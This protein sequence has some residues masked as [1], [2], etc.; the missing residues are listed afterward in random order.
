[1]VGVMKAHAHATMASLVTPAPR[2][3]SL[4]LLG[5]RTTVP[6]KDSVSK[7]MGYQAVSVSQDTLG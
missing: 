6:I 5:A 2:S 7:V 4:T 3:I 1:M